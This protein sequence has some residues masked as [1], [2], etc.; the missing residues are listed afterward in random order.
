MVVVFFLVSLFY[1]ILGTT[2]MFPFH[3]KLFPRSNDEWLGSQNNE[4]IS[5]MPNMHQRDA[6]CAH[7]NMAMLRR[8]HRK[9]DAPA[10]KFI[11]AVSVGE[12]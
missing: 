12:E 6:Y 4:S 10:W 5:V 3:S 2:V 7:I 11:M 8:T 1:L 9:Y